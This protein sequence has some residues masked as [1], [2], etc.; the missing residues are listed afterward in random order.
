MRTTLRA[1]AALLTLLG[2]LLA[3]SACSSGSSDGD[4]ASADRPLVIRITM[5]GSSVTPNGTRVDAA[6]RP[7]E[8]R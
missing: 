6:V 1:A 8:P 5:K 2:L 4:N 3:S 7:V